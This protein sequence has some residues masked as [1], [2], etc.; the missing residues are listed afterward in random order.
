MPAY[1]R[2]WRVHV[3]PCFLAQRR[4]L[5]R[6]ALAL[7]LVLHDKPAIPRPPA[8]MGDAEKGEGFRPPLT[9]L[10]TSQGRELASIS[11]VLSLWSV[12]PN[13][14]SR[15]LRSTSIRRASAAFSNTITKSSA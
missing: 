7:R 15:S 5:A 6:P 13:L 12:R 4:Q 1:Q 11:S 10:L 3:P 9:A 8:I 2:C 14:A